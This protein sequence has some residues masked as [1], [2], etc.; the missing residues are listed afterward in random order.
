[1]LG[2]FDSSGLRII[3]KSQV[4]GSGFFL[5]KLGSKALYEG[6]NEHEESFKRIEKQL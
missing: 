1:M 3:I 4:F 2:P 6:L 5:I